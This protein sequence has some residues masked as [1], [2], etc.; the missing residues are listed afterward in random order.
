MK[1]AEYKQMKRDAFYF[2]Y[3]ERPIG[4]TYK[5]LYDYLINKGYKIENEG[6]NEF[7]FNRHVCGAFREITNHNLNLPGVF[8]EAKLN[9]RNLET[10]SHGILEAEYHIKNVPFVNQRNNKKNDIDIYVLSLRYFHDNWE[11]GV[12]FIE[13]CNHI[14]NE[15]RLFFPDPV[16][17]QIYKEITQ[18]PTTTFN[19]DDKYWATIESIFRLLE[20]EE[21][22]HSLKESK[23]ARKEAKWAIGIS[24][25]TFLASIAISFYQINSDPKIHKD[26]FDQ[27]TEM[28]EVQQ[29]QN[30]DM[31]RLIKIQQDQ[32]E[33]II[34]L[35]EKE[36]KPLSNML[37]LKT[38]KK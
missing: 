28:A 5:E 8:A 18:P 26:Q 31:K 29:K 13:Y 24:I 7:K 33:R 19:P 4:R 27:I 15:K 20:Y 6:N 30:D 1:I 23:D 17:S 11:D 38:Q 3:E 10:L 25:V 2:F 32:N 37:K 22:Q 36:N 35:L 21:L 16:L 34:L 9:R 12:S 14:K